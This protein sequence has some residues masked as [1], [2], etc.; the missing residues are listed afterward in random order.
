[1]LIKYSQ[2]RPVEPPTEAT[3]FIQKVESCTESKKIEVS[4]PDGVREIVLYPETEIIFSAWVR[5][6][7][8]GMTGKNVS[9]W[10]YHI[11]LQSPTQKRNNTA[12]WFWFE[13]V[14]TFPQTGDTIDASV[15][16]PTPLLTDSRES[17]ERD[18]SFEL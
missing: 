8:W 15:Q 10:H 2:D 17:Q 16:S 14:P 1:M 11:R 18:D 3:Q 9:K 7:D 12:D 13:A 6:S 5:P 4:T